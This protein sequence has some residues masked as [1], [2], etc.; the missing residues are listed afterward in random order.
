MKPYGYPHTHASLANQAAQW[1][2]AQALA[3]E[4]K[5][6]EKTLSGLTERTA[7]LERGETRSLLDDI[8]A[9]STHV[10]RRMVGHQRRLAAS[11]APGHE[12]G[13]L[14]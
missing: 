1:P 3:E 12:V 6:F 9:L 8:A 14:P 11:P 13:G 7:R 2:D 5:R 4:L 10:T